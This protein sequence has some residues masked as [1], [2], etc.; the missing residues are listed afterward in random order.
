[1][2]TSTLSVM[3]MLA[4]TISC[5]IFSGFNSTLPYLGYSRSLSY[6]PFSGFKFDLA[7]KRIAEGFEIVKTVKPLKYRTMDRSR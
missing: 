5:S 6:S 7:D 3:A 4:S 2:P 1:M